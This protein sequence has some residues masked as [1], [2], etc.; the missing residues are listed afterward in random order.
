[1]AMPFLAEGIMRD[2]E[3]MYVKLW[4]MVQRIPSWTTLDQ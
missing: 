4:E 1:M 3:E 2:K